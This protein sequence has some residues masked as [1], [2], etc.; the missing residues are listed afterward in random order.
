[1]QL[2]RHL[3]ERSC[4]LCGPPD[5]GQV[6]YRANFDEARLDDFAFASRKLPE[7]M[8]LTL[9]ECPSCNLLYASPSLRAEFLAGAYQDAAYDSTEEANF[10]ARTYAAELPRVIAGM[11]A[12]PG[13]AVEIGSGNG[14]FLPYLCEAGFTQ[15]VGVEPSLAA[16]ERAR[17][18]IRPLIRLGMFD[19]GDFEK[20]SQALVACF[21]TIEH[22]ED[23]KALCEAARELLKPGGA[24]YLVGHDR[25]SLV[26]RLLG[27]RSPVFDIEHQQ[28]FNQT[29]MRH[30]LQKSGFTRVEIRSIRN[31]YPLAYW[32]R[33]LPAPAGLKKAMIALLR[34]LGLGGVTLGLNVGNQ[35]AVG[36]RPE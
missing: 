17:P 16:V 31:R 14:A 28:L 2:S 4:P 1:M 24:L 13:A 11:K 29:S 36:Y 12:A 25:D 10:A 3:K 19:P 8:H 15:V 6:R 5:R 33:L 18:E 35:A 32:V 22:V 21:Q 30:L 34:A 27:T 26:N 9:V 20:G 7:F 23:P